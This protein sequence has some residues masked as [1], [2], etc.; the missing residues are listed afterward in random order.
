MTKNQLFSKFLQRAMLLVAMVVMFTATSMAQLYW[1]GITNPGSGVITDNIILTGD[2]VLNHSS[3]VTITGSISGPY[4]ISKL[5]SGTL[6]LA[7]INTYT[8]TTTISN[9]TVVIHERS[10]LGNTNSPINLSSNR[11]TLR[12]ETTWDMQLP[13]VIYGPGNVEFSGVSSEPLWL[14]EDNTF[15]GTFT[16][17]KGWVYLGEGYGTGSVVA[18]IILAGPNAV[19]DFGH[20]HTYSGQISG[21]GGGVY[22]G[23]QTFNGVNTY[24]CETVIRGPFT[25]G[26]SGSIANSV[27]VNLTTAT[28]KLNISA[29]DKKIKALNSTFATAEV[30]LGTRTLIIG[31]NGQSDGGGTFAGI[32]SGTGNIYK[33]GTGIFTM[34]G[35]NT[36]TGYLYMHEGTVVMNGGKWAGGLS[37]LNYSNLTVKGNPTIGGSIYLSGNGDFN[38]DIT[39]FPY[40]KLNVTG[41]VYQTDGTQTFNIT[42]AGNVRNHVLIEAAGGIT[43]ADSHILNVS[44]QPAAYLHVNAP[45]HL[46]LTTGFCGGTGT[47]GDPIL[48]CTAQ[49][50]AMLATVVNAGNTDYNDKHYIL[51]NDIDLSAYGASWND[52]EGWIPIGSG[53][54]PFKG[55][56]DGNG[57]VITGLF[58]NNTSL[59]YGGLFGRI[60]GSIKNLGVKDVN[61]TAGSNT[62][63]L[64]GRIDNSS[65]TMEN[66]YA[67]G[68][69]SGNQSVGGLA[70]IVYPGNLSNCYTTGSVSGTSSWIGGVVGYLFSSCTVSNCYSTATVSGNS[71]IGG[72]VGTSYGNV[73]NCVAANST[74]TASGT[75]TNINRILGSAPSGTYTNNYA[76]EDMLVNGATIS[77]GTLNNNNGADKD[78]ATLQTL[79]FYNTS[80]NWNTAPWNIGTTTN[81]WAICDNVSLPHLTWQNIECEG[82]IQFCGGNGTSSNPYQICSAKELAQLALAVNEG[83]P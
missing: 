57:K 83:N 62:G 79:A 33:Y 61:I 30:I 67:T 36:T 60:E 18:D 28:A 4:S 44:N 2:V 35:N 52:G 7:G 48:I 47:S 20:S 50:L 72:V 78:M 76:N 65:S 69:V 25:L 26:T 37:K 51:N 14:G 41:N 17:E 32:F 77:G 40:S 1:N 31:S 5:G 70:G 29:G 39:T 11:G 6:T 19:V 15:T 71:S 38:M 59:F 43:S 64:V 68:S 53:S 73:K 8:G 27:A 81:I 66:C 9:G 13:R 80:G 56:F 55:V 21:T 3:A 58:I 23:A 34:S 45:T 63:G 22:V 46:L 24:T 54:N 74:I 42:A 10:G 12:I 82:V 16:I 49:D 75:T